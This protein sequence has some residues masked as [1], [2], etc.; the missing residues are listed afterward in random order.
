M[1]RKML[2]LLGWTCVVLTS[3]SPHLWSQGATGNITGIVLDQSNAALPGAKV[4]ATQET[5]GLT[6]ETLTTDAGEYR[7]P[8]LPV[9]SYTITVEM[10]G[11]KTQANRGLKLEV[12]QTARVDF[13]LELGNIQEIVTVESRA[14]MLETESTVTGH[15]DQE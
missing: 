14:P 12:Q 11:F 10:T 4:S 1:E 3:V 15:G 13:Q 2:R 7:L 6:R 9:G 8:L 5:T